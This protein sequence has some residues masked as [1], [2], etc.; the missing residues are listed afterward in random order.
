MLYNSCKDGTLKLLLIKGGVEGGGGGV[1]V[2]MNEKM[3]NA[4]GGLTMVGKQRGVEAKSS[5]GS[6]PCGAGDEV[7]RGGSGKVQV[8][9]AAKKDF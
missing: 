7:V 5:G 4:E 3:H 9:K 6:G 2:E 8:E 1:R